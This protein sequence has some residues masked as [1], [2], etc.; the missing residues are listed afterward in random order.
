[1]GDQEQRH[2][3]RGPEP[4]EQ[5]EDLGL[6]RD[7]ERGG[8]LVGKQDVRLGGQGDG[9]HGA[10]AHAAAQLV[11][12]APVPAGGVADAHFRQERLGPLPGLPAGQVEVRPD[13]F[14]DLVTNRQHRVEAGERILEH[15]GQPAAPHPAQRLASE[16]QQVGLADPEDAARLD[17][18]GGRHQPE[19]GEAGEGLA[20]A[21][22]ADQG[23]ELTG[24]EGEGHA[25]HRE[26][27][28]VRTRKTHP[29]VLDQQLPRHA[30][31]LRR[32]PLSA[33]PTRFTASTATTMARP[34]A[35]LVSGA[36][37][38]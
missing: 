34:G 18:A 28:A 3:P 36:V 5:L 14:R 23:Q 35:M 15:H 21:R 12:V 22:L 1:M 24:S 37:T 4:V 30:G 17:P 7:V 19:E 31:R 10:L 26:D 32:S 33:S 29:E 13:G 38:R 11:R 2:A 20:R 16:G 8:G 25:V 9:Q 27:P 6:H